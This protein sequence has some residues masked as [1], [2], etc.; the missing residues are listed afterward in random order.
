MLSWRV[1]AWLSARPSSGE[2][3]VFEAANQVFDLASARL[4]SCI[5]ERYPA[6]QSF[7]RS[8]KPLDS[9][10]DII[11]EQ[12]DS[13]LE[14]ARN[15]E[16][17]FG[18]LGREPA[19]R[20]ATC[21]GPFRNA[22]NR[23]QLGRRHPGISLEL[24]QSIERKPRFQLLDQLRCSGIADSKTRPTAAELGVARRRGSPLIGGRF[25]FRKNSHNGSIPHSCHCGKY[26]MPTWQHKPAMCAIAAIPA[27]LEC[28]RM[29]MRPN[30]ERRKVLGDPLFQFLRCGPFVRCVLHEASSLPYLSLS[31]LLPW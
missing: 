19:G 26:R 16:Q 28:P 5:S 14:D 25:C 3:A 22:E 12:L 9:G 8:R 6:A 7:L 10:S 21:Q 15:P 1:F 17:A 23:Y 18:F 13:L 31:I 30:L 2:D 29:L 20:P 4:G 24:P 27:R 11:I